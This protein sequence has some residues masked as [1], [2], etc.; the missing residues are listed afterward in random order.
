[1]NADER[2]MRHFP[3]RYSAAESNAFVDDTIRH[4]AEH[5][6][7]N[8]AVELRGSGAFIGFVGLSRPAPWH[9]CAG[10]IEIGWRLDGRHWGHGYATEA[11]RRALAVGFDELDL[12][13][14]VSFTAA[15]NL[16]SVA[17]M[18]RIG[19]EKDDVGFEHPRIEAGSPVRS[20]VVYRLR[21]DRW[22]HRRSR[23]EA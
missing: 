23:L 14:I 12:D 7:G 3:R 8:W 13:E 9:P 4:I 22:A 11:A 21:R 16:P 17:V 5:G 15:C 10:S 1:M 6:W 19:M 20:H 2:V 18:E